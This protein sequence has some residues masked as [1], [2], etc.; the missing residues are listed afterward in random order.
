MKKF[1]S[2]GK[3]LKT[4]TSRNFKRLLLMKLMAAFLLGTCMQVLAAGGTA[5]TVTLSKKNAS[6]QQV[7]RAINIQTGLD[8]IYEMGLLKDAR[9]IDIN[10][11]NEQV[12]AVLKICFAQQ[13]FSFVHVGNTIVLKPK[14]IAID[15][16]EITEVPVVID[17]VHGNVKDELNKPMIGATVTNKNNGKMV[18]TNADGSFTIEA[19]KGDIIEFSYVGYGLKQFTVQSLTAPIEINLAVE[20]SENAAVVVVGYGTQKRVNLTGAVSTVS[21][22]TIESRPITSVAQGLQGQVANLNI[23]SSNGSPGSK[24]T[25]DI[26]GYGGLGVSYS[27]LVI[28]DGVVGSMDDLNPN[29]IQSITV[30]KDASS[31]A[32]Y[33]AQAAYGVVL[34][35][36]K[37][38]RKNEKTS[39]S[40]SNNFS[41][42]APTNLPKTAGSLEFAKLFRE[43]SLN[44]G[45]GGVIDLETMGRIEQ[46]Y[47]HP[48]SIPNNVP[49]IGDPTRWSDWGDGRSNANEN[50]A[51]A[52]FKN[53]WSQMHNLSVKGG[54]NTTTYL[55][56]LG[57]TGDDGKLRY[58]NDYYKRFNVNTKISTDVTKWLTVGVNVRYAKEKI[59]TPAYYMNPNGGINSLIGWTTQVWPTIPL[60]DP[61][62][63]F[64]PAGRMAFIAQANPHTT[65][66]DNLWASGN[67]L[68]KIL[69]GLTFNVDF[70]YNKYMQRQTYSKGLIYS[71]SVQN[72]PYLDG[73]SPETTQAWDN[74]DNNDYYTTNIYGTYDKKWGDHGFKIMIGTQQQYQQS[75]GL[76]SNK[77]GLLMPTIPSIAT[78]TGTVQSTDALDQWTTLSYFGRINYNFKEKYLAEVVVRR[79]GSSR[80]ADASIAP[81]A[82]K[83]G[84]FPSFSLGWNIARESFFEPFNSYVQT[85]KLRGSWGDLGNMRGQ[86]YQ[87]VSILP[88]DPSSTYIMGNERIGMLGTPSLIAYNTWEKNRTLDFGIDLGLFRNRFLVSFDWYKRDVIGLITRGESLPSI[89]GATSPNTNNANIRNKGWEFTTSWTD[90]VDVAGKQLNYNVRLNISRYDGVVTKYSNPNGLLSDWYVGKK[91]GE[92]WGYITDHIMIDQKEADEMN[93]SQMQQKFGT[94]WTRGDMKYKDLDGSGFIDNG[95]NTLSD[96][97]DIR[98]IGNTTP[99]FNYG[100]GF[101]VDWNG[102]DLSLFLQGTGKRNYWLSGASA[103]GLGG[104]QW[105]SNVWKNTLNTWREDGSNLDPYWPKFYLSSTSKNLQVQTKYLDNASYCRVKNLQIGYTFPSRWTQQITLQKI[106]LYFSAD[107]LITFSKINEN[108]DPEQPSGDAYPLSKSLSFGINVTF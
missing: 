90:K 34:I 37:S 95:S 73:S 66:R 58:Y 22:K 4:R 15:K 107:N 79:D 100:F 105:N 56:S 71:W 5:Q 61:N 72:V 36:T 74:S 55:I 88:Y 96:H 27:P 51:K 18:T 108:F 31:A 106:R 87:Y 69:P 89:L 29:D 60:L 97:G 19:N 92:I 12:D 11:K 81:G 32:I 14:T 64:S 63:H 86:P 8:F 10:V 43:A 2:C 38:G 24:P 78:A 23:T 28:V 26:R 20:A 6:L 42:S 68:F 16:V 45:G 102:I 1:C 30:L 41:Y 85:L 70:T 47:Y 40:Y 75:F 99:K 76:Y 59:V 50:W 57:Y 9:P 35:T 17:P 53:Q 103:N 98:V 93:A 44:E 94:N 52:M 49:Q 21:G 83:W 25:F 54:S 33:G 62:G 3:L 48:G 101:N 80:Y 65:N 39:I 84:T 91:M 104:G 67:A 77:T 46:Y 82:N 7:F 13:P